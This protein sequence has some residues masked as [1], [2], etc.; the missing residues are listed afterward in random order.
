MKQQ[1]TEHTGQAL[2]YEKAW[3]KTVSELP[4]WKAK[5]I[6]NNWPYDN[7]SDA[8]IA[9]EVAHEAALRAELK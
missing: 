5:I 1:T 7:P 6:I 9:Q 2:R 3:N 4:D 8:R